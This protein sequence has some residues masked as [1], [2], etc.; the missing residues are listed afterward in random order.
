MKVSEVCL[1]ILL[2]EHWGLKNKT[3]RDKVMEKI[4]KGIGH[5]TIGSGRKQ[6]L[7]YKGMAFFQNWHVGQD[8]LQSEKQLRWQW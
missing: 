2:K 3:N 7:T 5:K 8:E 6:L 4:K 1:R